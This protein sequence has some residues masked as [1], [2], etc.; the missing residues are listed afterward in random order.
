MKTLSSF[1]LSCA[2]VI[3]LTFSVSAAEEN[4]SQLVKGAKITKIQAEHIVL[5]QVP[6]GR[7]KSAE[8]E[9]EKGHLVWSFD[10]AIPA[11]RNITEILVDA[12]SGQ[13]ISRQTETLRD[14]AREAAGD[15][16]K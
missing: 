16:K 8:I 7:V 9:K 2:T 3:G 13:I 1:F 4:P 6:H 15:T 11:T 5:A 14:Q 12:K 10:I